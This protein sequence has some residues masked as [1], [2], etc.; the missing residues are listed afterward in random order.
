MTCYLLHGSCLPNWRGDFLEFSAKLFS[1]TLKNHFELF[2]LE[3]VSGEKFCSDCLYPAMIEPRL[4][5]NFCNVACRAFLEVS[6]RITLFCIRKSWT[7]YQLYC[8][9]KLFPEVILQFGC[10]QRC[11]SYVQPTI[12]CVVGCGDFDI[13]SRVILICDCKIGHLFTFVFGLKYFLWWMVI[14]LVQS[15]VGRTSC[16]KKEFPLSSFV[17][18]FLVLM[19]LCLPPLGKVTFIYP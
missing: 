12:L 6:M 14:G 1:F 5:W 4:V 15:S 2:F 11:V 17:I 8:T 3:M 7:S 9:S 19:V 10:M 16:K 13:F 18:Q